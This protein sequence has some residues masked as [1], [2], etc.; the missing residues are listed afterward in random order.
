[1]SYRTGAAL[2]ADALPS[3]VENVAVREFL[4]LVWNSPITFPIL[5]LHT[6]ADRAAG[7]RTVVQFTFRSRRHLNQEFALINVAIADV[8]WNRGGNGA[9]IWNSQCQSDVF[10][11]VKLTS[12]THASVFDLNAFGGKPVRLKI[13]LDAVGLVTLPIN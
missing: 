8:A 2:A 3:I 1:M 7:R 11:S 10:P 9:V 12:R 4:D 13:Q 6:N 5:I